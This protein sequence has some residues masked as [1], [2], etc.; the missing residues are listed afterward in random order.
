MRRWPLP[1]ALA[2]AV[3]CATARPVPK[4]PE[5]RA[6]SGDATFDEFEEFSQETK[7]RPFDPL[8]GY[9]RFMFKVNDKFMLYV[10]KPL[11]KGYGFIVPEPARVAVDRAY[12]NL[13]FPVRFINCTMQAKLKGSATELGRF[14]V[15]STVGI[16]GL[17][18]PAGRWLGWEPC[19]E[20]FG[21]TLAAY[22]MGEGFP[23]VLPILGPT[24]LRDGAAMAPRF[25]VNPLT[26]LAGF[27][28]N[29]AVTAGERFN[30]LSL[31]IEE[32]ESIK[33]DALDPY[34]F[35][36]DAYKQNREKKIKE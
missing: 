22:G 31:H 13:Y 21:Q 14:V 32:Y 28:T 17:F 9:N 19:E 12:S 10:A 1:C 11:A 36:R 20:D 26:Y 33:R 2:L 4:G 27:E 30:Y 3:G 15:N 8:I 7:E 16:G 18:D 25:L 6:P 34:T 5:T 24:N 29:L 23:L 35:I